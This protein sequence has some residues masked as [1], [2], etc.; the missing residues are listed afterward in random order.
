[1]KEQRVTFADGDWVTV[2]VYS[3]CNKAMEVRI[4]DKSMQ[5]IITERDL[6]I[7]I[8]LKNAQQTL[9]WL[10]EHIDTTVPCKTYIRETKRKSLESQL[11]RMREFVCD[12]CED[13]DCNQRIW[14]L[15]AMLFA[16]TH[17]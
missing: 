17:S 2:Q 15:E 5:V 13:C 11:Q 14:D 9:E 16:H 3:R 6:E 7:P 8:R 10:I 1:M 4:L 12:E